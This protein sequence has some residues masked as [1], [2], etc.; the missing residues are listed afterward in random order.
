MIKLLVIL[1]FLLPS[2]VKP[3]KCHHKKSYLTGAEPG[4]YVCPHCHETFTQD[5]TN[6]P[7]AKPI[8]PLYKKNK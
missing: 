2:P 8:V 1:M 5:P 4:F 3:L 7:N 6:N